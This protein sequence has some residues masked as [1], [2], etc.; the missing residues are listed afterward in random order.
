MLLGA[1]VATPTRPASVAERTPTPQSV[2][3]DNPG[4]DAQSPTDAALTRLLEEP[5]GHKTDKFKTLRAHMADA[6]NWKRVRLFGYPTRTA[7]RYGKKPA[8]AFAV[9]KYEPAEDSDAPHACLEQFVRKAARL[10]K[11]FDI[12]IDPIARTLGKHYRGSESVDWVAHDREQEQQRA[13]A[14][15]HKAARDERRRKQLEARRNARARAQAGARLR[16]RLK[17]NWSGLTKKTPK[18][19]RHVAQLQRILKRTERRA[20]LAAHRATVLGREPPPEV[21]VFVLGGE[22]RKAIV[23][24]SP[25]WDELD[26][27]RRKRSIRKAQKPPPP[28][29]KLTP[30]E[31]FE[32]AWQHRAKRFGMGPMPVART[33]GRFQ[34]LFDRDEYVGALVAYDS[35]PGTCLVH[36]FAAKVGTD[37]ALAQRVVDRWLAEMAPRLMWEDQLREAPEHKNR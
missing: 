11:K 19:P 2:S 26:P 18:R 22:G 4:G 35:W 29:K 36:G 5:L 15:K 14:A 30:E 33:S 34:T 1:C 25:P 21:E 17:P 6:G 31:V 28:P 32:R 10:S 7:F 16:G 37:P 27:S 12:E 23:V 13:A 8:Y 20:H 3:A 24:V 9:V